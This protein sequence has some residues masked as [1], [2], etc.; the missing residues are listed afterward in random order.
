MSD[1]LHAPAALPTGKENILNKPAWTA[2]RSGL[3]AWGLDE[4]LPTPH[5][6]EQPVTKHY[7]VSK[8]HQFLERQRHLTMNACHSGQ[9]TVACSC[10]HGNKLLG[11]IKCGEFLR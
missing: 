1:Q 8:L 3:S 6:K 5:L 2:A 10:E 4:G 11:S 7:T 9:G